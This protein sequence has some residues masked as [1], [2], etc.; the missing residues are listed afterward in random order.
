MDRSTPIHATNA[1]S[2]IPN[3]PVSE[4]MPI[5]S[6]PPEVAKQTPKML[7]MAKHFRKLVVSETERLNNLSA[8]WSGLLDEASNYS[9]KSFLIF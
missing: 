1:A 7:E 6:V 8:R 4:S 9:I 5:D 2:F 3:I